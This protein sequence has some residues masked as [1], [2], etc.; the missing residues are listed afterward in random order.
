[1]FSAF[2][3]VASHSS[4][5][6]EATSISQ[7]NG[8]RCCCCCCCVCKPVSI[9]S[10]SSL[11]AGWLQSATHISVTLA[12]AL[13]DEMMIAGNRQSA[14]VYMRELCDLNRIPVR[15]AVP[16]S[17]KGLMNCVRHTNVFPMAAPWVMCVWIDVLYKTLQTR[18]ASCSAGSFK[19]Y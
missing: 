4:E 5:S 2:V 7:T 6:Q 16:G 13:A 8:Y 17:S 3:Y 15:P 11:V 12:R 10:R 19:A 14:I 1:M 9:S 18:F